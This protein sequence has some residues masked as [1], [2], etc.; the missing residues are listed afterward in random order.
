MS[1]QFQLR[2]VVLEDM[3]SIA[4]LMQGLGFDHSVQEIT[5]RW[6][7]IEDRKSNPALIA[8]ENKLAIGLIALHIA[9]MLFYPQPLARITTLVVIPNW[10]RRG[11]GRALVK[12]AENLSTKAGCDTIELT[13]GNHRKDAH[14]FYSSLGYE[15]LAQRMEKRIETTHV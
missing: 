6:T 9:P 2:P 11:V 13:T 10:R 8:L 3:Q 1:A 15:N 7:L 4:V 5:R 14:A 12:A